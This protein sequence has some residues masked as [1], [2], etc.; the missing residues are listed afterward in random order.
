MHP[1]K[2]ACLRW[3][4]LNARPPRVLPLKRIAAPVE[5][6]GLAGEPVETFSSEYHVPTPDCSVKPVPH[7]MNS[8]SPQKN[9]TVSRPVGDRAR[10]PRTLSVDLLL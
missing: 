8:Y 3:W 4:M 9:A 7:P 6:E 2:R 10:K 5:S 1:T